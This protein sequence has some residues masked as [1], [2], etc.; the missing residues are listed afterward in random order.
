MKELPNKMSKNTYHRKG[1]S[2][3][4]ETFE[5]KPTSQNGVEMRHLRYQVWTFTFFVI[6]RSKGTPLELRVC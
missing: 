2:E 6:F 3:W 5:N 4:A 1:V